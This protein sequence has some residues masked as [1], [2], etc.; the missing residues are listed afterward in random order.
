MAHATHPFPVRPFPDIRHP[1]V[2]QAIAQ[3]KW[4]ELR[5][6]HASASAITS[7]VLSH[8]KL[9]PVTLTLSERRLLRWGS[10]RRQ[11][12]R[13]ERGPSFRVRLYPGPFRRAPTHGRAGTLLQELA[14]HM[15]GTKVIA[16]GR[17]LTRRGRHDDAFYQAFRAVDGVAAD[18]LFRGEFAPGGKRE[19]A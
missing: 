18:A 14:H 4:N 9:P 11:P 7:L 12:A 3:Q 5:L 15:V 13:G 16:A 10:W 2:A 19:V 6:D 8:F 1:G 17:P